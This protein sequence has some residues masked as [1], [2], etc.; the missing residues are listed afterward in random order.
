[1]QPQFLAVNVKTDT[2]QTQS[3]DQNQKAENKQLTVKEKVVHN[4]TRGIESLLDPKVL[5]VGVGTL[6]LQHFVR[7][8]QES[9]RKNRKKG[10][11]LSLGLLWRLCRPPHRLKGFR[12]DSEFWANDSPYKSLLLGPTLID[13]LSTFYMASKEV[14][15][16]LRP[17]FSSSLDTGSLIHAHKHLGIKFRSCFPRVRWRQV[18]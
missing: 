16:F 5:A 14:S 3:Q 1:M 6:L 4:V 2:H 15:S 12:R 10:I 9:S 17:L 8:A 18:L 13:L 11:S 7:Q